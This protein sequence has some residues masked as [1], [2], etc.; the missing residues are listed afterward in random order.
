MYFIVCSVKQSL[1][2]VCYFRDRFRTAVNVLGDSYGAGIV[3]HLSKAD[4]AES[5]AAK[6]EDVDVGVE[7]E[8]KEKK[9]G[10]SN[11]AFDSTKM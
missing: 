5:D 4:L 10:V 11:P 8:V 2:S 1:V 9:N 6:L 7:Y 3:E